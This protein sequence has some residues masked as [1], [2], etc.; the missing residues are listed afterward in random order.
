[1][2]KRVFWV[3]AGV[4]LGVLAVSKATAYVRANTPDKARQFLL[5]PDQENVGM[6]TL[7]GLIDQFRQAQQVREEELNRQYTAKLS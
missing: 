3:A 4:V 5:G 7:Q 1:M 2:F 6:R